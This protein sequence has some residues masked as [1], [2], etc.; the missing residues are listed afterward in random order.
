MAKF[1]NTPTVVK[2]RDIPFEDIEYHFHKDSVERAKEH[3]VDYIKGKTVRL[4]GNR[5][6]DDTNNVTLYETNL[7]V[8]Q[9]VYWAC[10]ICAEIGD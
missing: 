3:W 2:I 5:E 6:F 8:D 4:T 7:H 9:L 1:F 10:E